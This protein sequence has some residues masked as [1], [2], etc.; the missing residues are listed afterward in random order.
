MVYWQNKSGNGVWLKHGLS[1][2][3]KCLEEIPIIHVEFDL[4]EV[5][6]GACILKNQECQRVVRSRP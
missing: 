6:S 5:I 3:S 1:M 2:Y 4:R